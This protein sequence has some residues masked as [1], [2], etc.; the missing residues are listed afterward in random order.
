MWS[1]D[2]RRSRSPAGPGCLQHRLLSVSFLVG[3]FA[4]EV[5]RRIVVFLFNS[6]AYRLSTL[7]FAFHQEISRGCHCGCLAR[8]VLTTLVT[9]CMKLFI[10][11][12]ILL[13]SSRW[14]ALLS[15]VA[16]GG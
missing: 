11:E 13:I 5:R 3:P 15:F 2:C 9:C 6:S 10:C 1:R 14:R 4:S 8:C 16:A 12:C 7:A